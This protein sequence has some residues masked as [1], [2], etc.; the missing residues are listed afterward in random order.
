MLLE[1][2][3]NKCCPSGNA[4]G[5]I[6]NLITWVPQFFLSV[7]WKQGGKVDEE[8]SYPLIGEWRCRF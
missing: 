1:A 3:I 7:E 8:V 4:T 6:S 5:A 2:E